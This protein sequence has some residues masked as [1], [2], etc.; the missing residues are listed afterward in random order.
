MFMLDNVTTH[1]ERRLPANW[2]ANTVTIIG[3]LGMVTAGLVAI[4]FGGLSYD[5]AEEPLPRWVFGLA[6]FSI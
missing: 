1:V 3:N 4:C 6:A 5:K 2:T